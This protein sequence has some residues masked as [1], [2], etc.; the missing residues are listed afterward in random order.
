MSRQRI[1]PRGSL[2]RWTHHDHDYDTRRSPRCELDTVDVRHPGA[3]GNRC[4]LRREA[5]DVA[6]VDRVCRGA[7]RDDVLHP[8]PPG[9]RDV[10]V[11][12]DFGF[13]GLHETRTLRFN[14]QEQAALRRAAAIADEAR[15][16]W[17][18]S[19][20]YEVESESMDDELA[21]IGLHV[22]A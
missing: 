20:D 5:F 2:R 10:R 18:E 17:R 1:S 3:T 13:L 22:D 15:K 8:V 7:E 11:E 6:R 4:A 12:V 16:L 19:V 21:L 14:K 9:E